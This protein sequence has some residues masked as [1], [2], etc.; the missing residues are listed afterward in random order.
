ML[1]EGRK[2]KE[3][4]EALFVSQKTIETHRKRIM[5]KLDLHSVAELT[6]IFGS[7]RSHR[8][9]LRQLEPSTKT[10]Q[11]PISARSPRNLKVFRRQIS[12]ISRH[13]FSPAFRIVESADSPQR[14]SGEALSL[15]FIFWGRE[16]DV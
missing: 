16:D 10:K 14:R 15:Q 3:I 2:T 8:Y 1:S 12:G 7:P 13:L 5:D 4:A 9:P 6:K 11:L